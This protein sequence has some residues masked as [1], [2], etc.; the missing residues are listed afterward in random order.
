MEPKAAM[1][2][3]RTYFWIYAGRCYNPEDF[4]WVSYLY[5]VRLNTDDV[6]IN[7]YGYMYNKT[8]LPIMRVPA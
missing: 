4:K 2:V 1:P 7:Y 3:R 5:L 8:S 6:E